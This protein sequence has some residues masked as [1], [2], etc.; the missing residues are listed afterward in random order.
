MTHR[1]VAIANLHPRLRMDRRGVARVVRTLD[2]SFAGLV[3]R[4]SGPPGAGEI[5]VAFL[6]DEALASLHSEYL[7]DPAPT[8]VITF[9]FPSTSVRGPAGE[10]CISADAAG[11]QAGVRGGRARGFRR[12]LTLYLV[13]GWLHLAGHDDR[14]P[15]ARRSMRRAETKALALIRAAGALPDFALVPARKKKVRAVRAGRG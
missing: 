9:P 1:T 15:A 14:A 6:T 5:S 12:E 13:H 2:R 10:I 4:G 3:P 8:D 7:G 11:R